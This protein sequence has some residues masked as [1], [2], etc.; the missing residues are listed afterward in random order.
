M[1][2]LHVFW[3]PP[4]T[5]NLP[6]QRSG[7]SGFRLQLENS[8]FQISKLIFCELCKEGSFSFACL[9]KPSWNEK[10]KCILSHGT[11]RITFFISGSLRKN[12]LFLCIL[13]GWETRVFFWLFNLCNFFPPLS[14]SFFPCPLINE[15]FLLC[16]WKQRAVPHE[17]VLLE[18]KLNLLFPYTLNIES[19][20]WI[21]SEMS[22]KGL[23][24]C[25]S[26]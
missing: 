15:L 24:K 12:I 18:A 20:A 5:V 25:Q 13:F 22:D 6:G 26:P 16:H 9:L 7:W 4:G 1:L 21:N 2:S 17:L 8:T 10:A 23:W 3:T 14:A 19:L 11:A